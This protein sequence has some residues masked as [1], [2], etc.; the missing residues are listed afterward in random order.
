ML[1][2]HDKKAQ[3]I[4]E[5]TFCMIVVFLMIYGVV[6]IFQWTGLDL[7]Q[8]RITHDQ[9]LVAGINT[10]WGQ[11]K[12]WDSNMPPRCLAYFRDEEG[13]LNQIDPYFYEPVR[14]NAVWDGN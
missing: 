6:K 2:L 9:K 4:L 8:R 14:M 10:A 12:T 11:C 3:A 7:A 1:D 13:P 5:F